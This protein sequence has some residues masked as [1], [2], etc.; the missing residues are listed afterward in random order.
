MTEERPT[1]VNETIDR[2]EEFMLNN[3]PLAEAK[4]E[5]FFVP[6]VYARRFT[7]R[8]GLI[9]TSKIH[10]Q[11]H[12]YWVV[13]GDVSV[14]TEGEGWLRIIGP[15]CGITEPGTR[16][17]LVTHSETVWMT[18]QH[19]EHKDPDIIEQELNADHVNPFIPKEIA[20]AAQ[21]IC[22]GDVRYLEPQ[23]ILT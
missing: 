13:R 14:W 22:R 18:F 12:P 6:E 9:I 4:T 19:T 17:I 7:A 8:A 21:T 20:D 3:L 2:I 16:R 11:R 15:Y 23:E 1:L 10:L 5:H